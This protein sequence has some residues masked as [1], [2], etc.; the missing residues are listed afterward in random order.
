MIGKRLLP[1]QE[2]QDAFTDILFNALLGFA[3]MFALAFMLI[4]PQVTDGKIIPKAEF[5][6]TAHWANTRT[7]D[8][9]LIVEDSLGNLVWFDNREAGLMHLDR[10]DRGLLGDA[11]TIGGKRITNDIN[12]EVVSLRGVAAGEYVVNLL[13]YKS[14]R[15]RPIEVQLK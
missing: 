1:P 8:V 15:A 10:D 6:I 5:L 11:I 14:P 7:D 4:R 9:D 3:F 2:G 12:Q 13:H